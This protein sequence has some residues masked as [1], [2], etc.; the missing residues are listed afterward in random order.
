MKKNLETA[1]SI[2]KQIRPSTILDAPAGN[3]WLA[4][5]IDFPCQIDGIDL[6]TQQHPKYHSFTAHDLDQGLPEELSTYEVCVCCEGIEHVINP[7]R[8]LSDL[9]HHLEPDGTLILSTP[10]NW[11]PAS[12]FA[13]LLRGFFPSFPSLVGKIKR[14]SHMHTIPWNYPQLYLLLKLTGFSEIA[15]HPVDEKSPKHLVEYLFGLPHAL[16]CA[17][18]KRVATST[19]EREYWSAAGSRQSLF[20]RKLVLSA[21]KPTST[22][23]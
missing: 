21:R 13:Y 8:L 6:Y 14:G 19:E 22:S 3:G 5:S 17:N 20:G 4:E 9:F 15:L 7:G 16:Y 1:L 12:R 18:R 2:V 23:N 11:Y 10:N